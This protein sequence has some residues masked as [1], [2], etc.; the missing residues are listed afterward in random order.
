M[1][2]G[3]VVFGTLLNQIYLSERKMMPLVSAFSL[4]LSTQHGHF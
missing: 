2:S 1:G 3:D 4:V